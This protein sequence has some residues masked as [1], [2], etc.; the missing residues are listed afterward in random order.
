MNTGQFIIVSPVRNEARN[1]EAT[2]QSVVAQTVRPAVWVVVDD[3]STDATPEIVKRYATDHAW[4]RL[5]TLPDRG[6]YDLLEAGELKAFLH[7]LSTVAEVKYEFLAK[8]D[9]DIAFDEH[10][11]E[12]LLERFAENPRLGIASGMCWHEEKGRLVKEPDYPLHVRGAMRIYRKA[13]WDDIGGVP[14]ALGWDAIDCYKARMHGWDTRSFDDLPVKHLVKTWSKGGWLRGRKR[15]GR[16]DY[17][18][19]THPL[20]VLAKCVRDLR[21]KP[22]IISAGALAWGYF[23]PWLK[24]E[25]RIPNAELLAF[26]RREQL[27]RLFSA[28]RRN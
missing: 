12:Q 23:R 8:L 24:R 11:Y 10:Y 5:V 14:R 2:L 4:I 26:V 6:Y 28:F 27:H 22:Y 25:R 17:L 21:E 7:G 20:F 13:C 19:G 15:S 1:I 9:G 3:G 18:M 16:I